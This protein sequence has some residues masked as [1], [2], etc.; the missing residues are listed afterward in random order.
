MKQKEDELASR[1][2]SLL[3]Q[4]AQNLPPRTA[5]RLAAARK[6]ALARH[7][8]RPVSAWGWILAMSGGPQSGSDTRRNNLR[9]VLLAAA[10]ISAVALALTWHTGNTSPDIAEID[11]AL[12][13]D[14]LPINA[15]LDQGFDSWLKR[16]SR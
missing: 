13:T 5:E 8:A 6:Q 10:L 3:D 7:Q 12:L 15:F 11:A 14:E 1:I 2:A 4:G 9:V 16:G